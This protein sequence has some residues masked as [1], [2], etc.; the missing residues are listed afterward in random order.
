MKRLVA[1]FALL[2]VVAA[3]AVSAAPSSSPFPRTRPMA[4]PRLLPVFGPSPET[5]RPRA[6]PGTRATPVVVASVGA[7]SFT[8][9][10]SLYPK[11]RPAYVRKVA[12]VQSQPRVTTT[13]KQGSICGVKSIRG[14][15]AA[16]I[17]GKLKGCGVKKPVRV[18]SVDGVALSRPAVMNCETAKAL[19]SWVK[20]GVKPSVGRLGGGLKSINVIADYSCRTRN[21]QPG[22]KISEHGRGKAVDVAGVTLKNGKT[23]S[24][25]KGWG[26]PADGK[27]LRRMHKAACGPFGTVLGPNSDRYHKDHFHLDTASYRSGSYCR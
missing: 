5:M 8:P 16:P 9:A 1:S 23:I 6:R 22:A 4:M 12:V 3:S 17:P 26:K 13:G 18:S 2:A 10:R 25:L 7:A 20:N 14:V 11:A 19:N 15:K 27:V 21:N 24:V